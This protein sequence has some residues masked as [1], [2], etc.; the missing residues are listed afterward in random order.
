[1]SVLKVDCDKWYVCVVCVKFLC[2]CSV[3]KV[4]S[5]LMERFMVMVGVVVLV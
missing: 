2:L 5:C 1:M 3:V 4:W